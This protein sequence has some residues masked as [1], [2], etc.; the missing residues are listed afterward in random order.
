MAEERERV[1]GRERDK[2]GKKKEDGQEIEGTV[3]VF[4]HHY[5]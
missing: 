5:G 4:F 1:R 3:A 2:E